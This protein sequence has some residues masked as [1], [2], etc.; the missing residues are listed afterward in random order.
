MADNF[1]VDVPDIPLPEESKTPEIEDTFQGAF[2]FAVVGCGQGGGRLAHTFWNYG[3][4]KVAI[5]NT[6]EQDLATIDM[7]IERKFLMGSG[8]AGKNPDV[9]ASLAKTYKEDILDF[10]RR[11]FGSGFDRVICCASAAGGTGSGSLIHVIDAA[12]E[13]QLSLK[14]TSK[15][16][17]VILALPKVSEGQKLNANAYRILR[18][19]IPLVEKGQVSPLILVDNE[20]IS[21]LYPKLTVD[22]FWGMANKS[23]ISLFHLFNTTSIRESRY[24]SFDPSDLRTILDSGLITFGATPVTG[25]EDPTSISYAVRSSLKKN[26][27]SGGVSLDTGTIAGAMVIGHEDVLTKVPQSSIDLAFEQLTRILKPGNTVH[28]GIYR[29][30]KSGLVVYAIIG[31]LGRPMDKMVELRSLGCVVDS[32]DPWPK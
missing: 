1:D 25:W 10:M 15:K 9:A 27:L 8:G 22:D 24:T 7:P 17:G 2:K 18:D 12:F 3:Y 11:S 28:R 16:V 19:I 29:G 5:L 20:K 31:G 23:V 32:S 30:N 13:L 6:S 4:R 21:T 14:T 26:I